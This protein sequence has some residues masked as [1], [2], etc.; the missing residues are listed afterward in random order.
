MKW[1][2]DK[3]KKDD[4]MY[5]IFVRDHD[6]GCVCLLCVNFQLLSCSFVGMNMMSLAKYGCFVL[7]NIFPS[8]Q[9]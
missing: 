1:S 2:S 3:K 5:G 6:N 4:F 8:I 7:L 9:E